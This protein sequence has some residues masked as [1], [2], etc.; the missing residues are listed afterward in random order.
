[1]RYGFDGKRLTL[2]EIGALFNVTRERIRQIEA[3]ALNKL[4][5]P[6]YAKEFEK[7]KDELTLSK[8]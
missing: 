6:F 5:Q 4:R 2:E 3:K 8:E 7:Y 1:M